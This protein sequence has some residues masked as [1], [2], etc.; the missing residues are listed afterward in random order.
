MNKGIT[1]KK[2]YTYS[3][4]IISALVVKHGF[5][6]QY[7]RQCLSGNRESITA[8]TIRKEYK[9]LKSELDKTIEKFKKS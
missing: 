3:P 7:I 4:E 2:K 9:E 8:D 1:K 5:S 6:A